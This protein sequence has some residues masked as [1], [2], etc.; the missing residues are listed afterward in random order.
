MSKYNAD[1]YSQC[2]LRR[3]NEEIVTFLPKVKNLKEGVIVDIIDTLTDEKSDGWKVISIG[4][5][6]PKELVGGYNWA[7]NKSRTDVAKG[8]F[9]GLCF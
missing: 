5:E 7:K 9:T 1:I 3:E 8:T 2:L 6:L 4:T